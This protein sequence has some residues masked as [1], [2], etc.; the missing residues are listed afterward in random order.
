MKRCPICEGKINIEYHNFEYKQDHKKYTIT[1]VK[2]YVCSECDE[3][4][5]D[6]ETSRQ[7]DEKTIFK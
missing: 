3:R 2:Y 7:I 1:D 6:E 4:F 5:I